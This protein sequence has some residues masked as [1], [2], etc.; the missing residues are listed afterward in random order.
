MAIDTKEWL[1]TTLTNLLTVIKKND[2]YIRGKVANE[3]SVDPS[4]NT[5]T[6]KL[7]DGSTIVSNPIAKTPIATDDIFDEGTST[8]DAVSV[9]QVKDALTA[10]AGKTPTDL[11]VDENLLTMKLQD[12]TEIQTELDLDFSISIIADKI[13]DLPDPSANDKKWAVVKYDSDGQDDNGIYLSTKDADGNSSWVQVLSIPNEFSIQGLLK[14]GTTEDELGSA[15]NRDGDYGI[16]VTETS[17]DFRIATDGEWSPIKMIDMSAIIATDEE[18]AE[19][20]ISIKA[21]S[22]AQ[23]ASLFT[24]ETTISEE[25]LQEIFDNISV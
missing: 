22:V 19:G 25:T 20:T 16:I 17:I 21:V 8:T 7:N 11:Y 18:F 15:D 14:I 12:G 6:L 13:T 24:A 3:L 9:K 5:I 10:I 1:K 23:L 2:A 4:A